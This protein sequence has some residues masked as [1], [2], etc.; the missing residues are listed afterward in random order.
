MNRD[1]KKLFWE[2]SRYAVIIFGAIWMILPFFWLFSAS[3]MTPQELLAF[4]PKILPF[5][6][7]WQNYKEVVKRIPTYITAL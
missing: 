5:H 4:P 6:P 3:L 7:Q 2:T 1:R